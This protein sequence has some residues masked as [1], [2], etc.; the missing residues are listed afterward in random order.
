MSYYLHREKSD[1]RNDHFGTFKINW[2]NGFV[3]ASTFTIDGGLTVHEDME[4]LWS[5]LTSPIRD[6]RESGQGDSSAQFIWYS[7]EFSR[8]EY[9]WM[10]S[11]IMDK[12]GDSVFP[13]KDWS[14]GTYCVEIPTFNIALSDASALTNLNYDDMVKS[15]SSKQNT[16]AETLYLAVSNYKSTYHTLFG[17]YPKTTTPKAARKAFAKSMPGNITIGALP[18][19]KAEFFRKAAYPGRQ[20]INK[21]FK[22]IKVKDAISADE[23]GS[24]GVNMKEGNFPIGGGIKTR[25]LNLDHVGLYEVD[26]NIASKP[27]GIVPVRIDGRIEYP[28]SGYFHTWLD[29]ETIEFAS[30]QGDRFEISEGYYWDR[31]ENLFQGLMETCEMLEKGGDKGYKMMAK[32]TRNNLSGSFLPSKE[33]QT[34]VMGRPGKRAIQE[35]DPLTREDTELYRM[36]EKSEGPWIQPQIYALIT[37]RKRIKLFSYLVNI[38]VNE[39]FKVHTDSI[40]GTSSAITDS[41]MPFGQGWGYYGK[42]YEWNEL[43]VHGTTSYEGLTVQGQYINKCSGRTK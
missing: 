9:P 27:Y 6:K 30:Q 8:Q 3:K 5:A 18:E 24:Y 35:I 11:F 14:K 42:E 37:A 31:T 17:V 1:I 34:H 26:V 15:F 36:W 2:K 16:I 13:V 32:S 29:S 28:T 21:D 25:K 40:T 23:H 7:P 4:S 39:V 43:I 41:G 22:D 10:E 38:P 19:R 20:F 33:Y 12:K